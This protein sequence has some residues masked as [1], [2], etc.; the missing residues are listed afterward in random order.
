M[1]FTEKRGIH[2]LTPVDKFVDKV[3]KK[4]HGMWIKRRINFG[5]KNPHSEE[6]KNMKK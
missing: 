3:D 6:N 1:S 2:L 4:T 5:N